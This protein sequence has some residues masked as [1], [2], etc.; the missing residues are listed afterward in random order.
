MKA[1][2]PESSGSRTQEAA[3]PAEVAVDA[4][5]ASAASAPAVVVTANSVVPLLLG[6]IVV[7]LR[8]D[9]FLGHTCAIVEF[10]D[11]DDGSAPTSCHAAVGTFST[12]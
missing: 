7:V 4:V 9:N 12:R 8:C 11:F 3:A 6:D 2:E 5:T 1:E 10:G